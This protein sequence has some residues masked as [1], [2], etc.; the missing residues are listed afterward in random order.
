MT[1]DNCSK[2]TNMVFSHE[3]AGNKYYVNQDTNEV[4]CACG[5]EADFPHACSQPD[6]WHEQH[7][8]VMEIYSVELRTIEEVIK[9][10]ESSLPKIKKIISHLPKGDERSRYI[11]HSISYEHLLEVI[12]LPK[13]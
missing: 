9:Y 4:H 3:V 13:D 8:F 2:M 6:S 7:K 1:E 11:G 5:V 12:K 10:L